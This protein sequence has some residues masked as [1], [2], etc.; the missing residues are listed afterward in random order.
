M[1]LWTECVNDNNKIILISYV[2]DDWINLGILIVKS[3]WKKGVKGKGLIKWSNW[4]EIEKKERKKE[5]F[6]LFP[7]NL[8]R[9]SEKKL[10]LL[11]CLLIKSE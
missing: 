11:D 9:R 8:K 5:F 10:L 4:N 2:V 7:L 3:P 6:F 1:W